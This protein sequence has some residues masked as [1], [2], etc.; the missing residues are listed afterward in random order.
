MSKN[1]KP[2]TTITV[3]LTGEQLE[4]VRRICR[5]RHTSQTAYL[6]TLATEQARDELLAYAV[7]EYLEDR[8]SISELV[9]RTGLDVTS[10]M[11]G[12]AKASEGDRR[13]LDAFLA[14][15]KTVSKQLKDPSFYK[16]ALRAVS[17]PQ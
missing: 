9:A 5:I 15:A 13:V 3:R 6:A 2:K 7:A 11:D 1:K 14:A 12:I 16:A 4:T 10:I 17:E 8:A